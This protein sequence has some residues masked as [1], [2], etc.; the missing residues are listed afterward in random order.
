[1]SG[2]RLSSHHAGGR[3]HAVPWT[4]AWLTAWL[5]AWT[6]AAAAA[7]DRHKVLAPPGALSPGGGVELLQDYGAFALF[8][9]SPQ[10]LRNLPPASRE[11]LR[12]ADDMDRVLLDAYPFH[13]RD[14]VRGLPDDLRTDDPSGPGLQLI[15]FVGP[16]LG[17]W[18]DEVRAL[19]AEPVHAVAEN[20]YL[21]WTDD[22][23]RDALDELSAGGGPVQLS[24]PYHPW[25]KLGPSLRRRLSSSS[26]AE[27]ANPGEPLAVTVQML[28][29][30]GREASEEA[31][32][33]LAVAAAGPWTPVLGY[34][35]RWLTVRLGDVAEIAR[36][37]DV[38]WVGE[39]LPRRPADEVQAQILAG[40][41]DGGGGPATPGYL[42]F[43]TGLGF[44]AAAADYPV[45]DVADDG[46][47]NGTLT[48]GDPTFYV[49]GSFANPP[50]LI[51]VDNCTAAANGG[52]PRGHGHLNA[53]IA[54]G[55]DDRAGFPFRDPGGYRRGLG[56][57]PFGRFSG[58]KVFNGLTFDLSACGGTDTA[59]IQRLQNRGVGISSNSWGCSGCAG[60]YDDS[61]QAYD[62]GTRDADLAEPGDQPLLFFFAAGN[63]GPG[64]GHVRSPGNAKN[65]VTVGAVENDRPSDENGPWTDGCGYGPTAADDA[66]QIAAYSSRGPA[67]GGRAKPDLVAPGTHLQG[68]AST[69]PQYAGAGVCDTYRPSGQLAL[70]ASTGTSFANP[71]V[72]GLGAL[73]WWWLE[74]G[75]LD[76]SGEGPPSPA[77][78]KAYLIAHAAYV[79][80][81]GAGDDLPGAAQGYGRPDMGRLFDDLGKVLIDQTEVFDDSGELWRLHVVVDDPAEP[82]RVVL[83]YTDQA[84]AIGASPRVN[85]LDLTVAVD[86]V[87]AAG[88]HFDGPFSAAGGAPDRANNVEAVFLPPAP[89]L[90][91][92]PRTGGGLVDVTVT[93]FHVAGDGV[94]GSGDGNDQDFAL[95]CSNCRREPL[96]TLDVS[97]AAAAVCAPGQAVF[98]VEVGSVLGFASQVTLAAGSLPAGVG[99][100]LDPGSLTPPGASQLTL[101]VAGAA[102]PGTYGVELA[103]TGGGLARAVALG[104]T[105][106]DAVPAPPALVE[107]PDGAE[108][109]PAVPVFRWDPSAQAASYLLEVATDAGFADIVYSAA[110]SAG[111]HLPHGFAL[112]PGRRYYWR[113]RGGNACGDGGFSAVHSFSTRNVPPVL[114]V[115]DD[116]GAPDVRGAYTSA[117][118]AL[119]VAYDVWDTGNSDDE[120]DLSTLALY[121]AV[122][123]FSGAE[124]GGLADP[125]R[126]GPGAAGEAALAGY[127]DLDRAPDRGCLFLS[128]QDYLRDH[129]LPGDFPTA[130][131]TGYLGL[132]SGASYA[133][134]TQVLG[135]GRFFGGFGP[136]VLSYAFTNFSDL[137]APDPAA[138]LAFFGDHGNAAV[139]KDGAT[140]R[141]VWWGFPFE[142]L[143]GAAVRTE[144]M[145]RVVEDV[146]G[147]DVP[148]F[149]DGFESGDLSRWSS[150]APGPGQDR[151]PAAGDG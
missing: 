114:L 76:R 26:P 9:V 5:T 21:V 49:G 28:R 139:L 46:I 86:G 90:T 73:V 109:V 22:R 145:R 14:G 146:C 2:T 129:G 63:E 132:A 40:N 97:P 23:G 82:L 122:V 48:P 52:S 6:A 67:P 89:P 92:L 35:N 58:T 134:H 126:A 96:F 44:S 55:Y 72:A 83:A 124:H 137:L 3:R 65:V 150:A 36:L 32:A 20:A 108:E 56:V 147:A 70:A 149:F 45:V 131:M 29:H 110:E 79:T 111:E 142:A 10:A 136:Y 59:L 104:L 42:G 144:A 64:P 51:A 71:A 77:L 57:N 141:T 100:G 148:A 143:P 123:W 101:D 94:P 39:R 135:A 62:A 99:A 138:E 66:M 11:R 18:L 95:V 16:I 105:V 1:M 88:N 106:A 34:Q 118:D 130:F 113:V 84:G 119:G 50:R 117:L 91:G 27:P 31:V 12:L 102:V 25:F 120:P 151:E 80:G 7:P 74:N 125:G 43:L 41:V 112:A 15:Q 93:A 116:D 121:D 30:A 103:A 54:M 127:L 98:D 87:A 128:S 33:G 75:G 24:L 78:V 140:F 19:G 81:S 115:D 133:G 85:D 8:A 69:H 17:R 37:A 60:L 68:T 107:P 38:V 53:S 61:A 4:A 13:T 47:G